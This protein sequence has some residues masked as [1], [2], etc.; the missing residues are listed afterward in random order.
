MGNPPLRA[1]STAHLAYLQGWNAGIDR[2]WQ[3]ELERWRAEGRTAEHLG[4]DGVEWDRFARR[5]QLEDTA[6][7]CFENLDGET[8]LWC[9]RYVDGINDALAAGHRI[10]REFELTETAPH[11]GTLGLRWASSWSSTFSSQLSRTSCFVPMWP[12]RWELRQWNSSA[13]KLRCGLAAT[14]G[15][16]TARAPPQESPLIAGDPHRLLELPGT[17]QQVR[18]S[19]PEFDVVGFAFPGVPGLPHF[20]HTGH[21]TWAITN[22]MIRGPAAPVAQ[23]ERGRRRAGPRTLGGAGEQRGGR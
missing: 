3:I 19:C 10:G 5:A 8:Q 15:P 18:L 4:Q 12:G 23:P 1:D 14:P 9:R 16:S 11:P 13:S 20:G 6:R 17:Y 22:A 2:S 21:A 7:K